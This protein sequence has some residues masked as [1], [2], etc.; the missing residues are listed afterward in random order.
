MKVNFTDLKITQAEVNKAVTDRLLALGKDRPQ[1]VDYLV[2]MHVEFF[3]FI[4]A[5]GIFKFWKHNHVPDKARVLDELADVMAFF[6]SIEAAEREDDLKIDLMLEEAEETLKDYETI[7]IIR[8]VSAAIQ[9]GEELSDVI[10]MGVALEV[11]RRTVDATWEEMQ[12][13]YKKKS[14]ENIRRQKEGY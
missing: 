14:E 6:L 12:D 9:I 11:A 13:A 8:A 2:A 10:L 7:A 5:V 1:G 4:N 3:E